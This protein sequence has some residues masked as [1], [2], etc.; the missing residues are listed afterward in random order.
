MWI[1]L[2]RIFQRLQSVD[3]MIPE[4]IWNF[5]V[6]ERFKRKHIAYILV[7]YV[8]RNIC[9]RCTHE[10]FVFFSSLFCS[11]FFLSFCFLY[12]FD[13][14]SLFQVSYAIYL[15]KCEYMVAFP[16]CTSYYMF[17]WLYISIICVVVLILPPHFIIVVIVVYHYLIYVRLL[18]VVIDIIHKM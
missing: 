10:I 13:T 17:V 5:N 15:L 6:C 18:L 12:F 14:F 3:N 4:S 8:C 16:Q 1:L 9:Q 11:I 7:M 2:N